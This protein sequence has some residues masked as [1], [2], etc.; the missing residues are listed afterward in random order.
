MPSKRLRVLLT[1][2][3]GDDHQ[4][5]QLGGSVNANLYG[6]KWFTAPPVDQPTLQTA[7]TDF[8]TS[9]AAA[10][11][12]GIHVTANKNKKR[13]ILVGL[14]RQL[15]LYVQANCNDDLAVLVSSGFQ[16]GST[17]RARAPL[18]KPVI[19]S[20]DQGNS[21]QLLV[22][23]KSIRNVR[24]WD[25]ECAPVAPGGALGQMQQLGGFTSSRS[26]PITGLTVGTTYSIRVRAVGGTTRYSDWSDPVSHICT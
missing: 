18:P 9:V 23:V 16:A 25:V 14:L 7:L 20:V 13:H 10:A 22:T 3:R 12:G 11:Q 24:T 8:T 17:T 21:T 6:N 2:T 4:V 15:A 5:E 26:I 1:F 19:A